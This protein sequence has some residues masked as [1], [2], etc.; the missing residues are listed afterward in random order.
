MK[1]HYI[2]PLLVFLVVLPASAQVGVNTTDPTADLDVNGTLRVRKRIMDDGQA[3]KLLGVDENGM[4][5]ELEMDENIY[6][7]GDK[8]KSNTRRE[9]IYGH[10]VIGLN[11]IDDA[12]S[13]VW[14]GGT[15]N[16]K[17]V[18]RLQS[19]LGL[20]PITLNGLEMSGFGTPEEAHGITV[21]VYS[22]NTSITLKDQ[23]LS[24]DPNNRFALPGGHD[25]VLQRYEMVQLMYDG[26]LKRW[27]VMSRN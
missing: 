17:S 12:T 10:T 9:G 21:T 3:I 26:I 2:L 5:L 1:L 6:I 27:L 15:G 23:V 4:I 20:L 25:V 8:V 19:L 7:E 13:I 14:P 22:P 18:I 16:G 24:S 11:I